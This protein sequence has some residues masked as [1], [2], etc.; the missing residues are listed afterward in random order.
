[1][2]QKVNPN[3]LRL[4]IVKSWKSEWCFANKKYYVQFFHEDFK[5]R[6]TLNKIEEI[7]QADVADIRIT[8]YGQK[9]IIEIH[10]PK[11]GIIIGVNGESI[12]NIT[13]TLQKETSKK[14]Q[15]KVT[16][17]KKPETNAQVVAYYIA[18]QIKSRSP[19]RKAM[20]QAISNARKNGVSG[21]KIRVSGRLSGADMARSEEMKEGR[22]PLQT[23]KANIDYGFAESLT[24]FGII[25]I[26]VWVY[27]DD[28]FQQNQ[29]SNLNS[30]KKNKG[31]K[32]VKSEKN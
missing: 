1:M 27:L 8:R 6:N 25:G 2:G 31:N 15:I 3:G 20:K 5:L 28:A 26:K 23:L 12:N 19:F 14:I 7:K 13:A 16:E 11:P 4:G 29:S 22:V 30:N 24:T 10:T 17:I 18:K 32:N 21:I 9:I